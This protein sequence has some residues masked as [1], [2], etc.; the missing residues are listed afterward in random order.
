[1]HGKQQLREKATDRLSWHWPVD[2]RE[3]L[4]SGEYELVAGAAPVPER[5]AVT[6]ALGQPIPSAD[7]TA[8]QR[9]A[10]KE[11]RTDALTSLSAAEVRGISDTY[12]LKYENKP[13]AIEAILEREFPEA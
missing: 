5:P 10:R 3:L 2:V 7:E 8:E 12:G 1:M 6:T 11:A 13:A 9:A 4:R